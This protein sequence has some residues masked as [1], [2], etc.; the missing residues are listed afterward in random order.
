M[1]RG[2]LKILLQALE[3]EI[4]KA[5]LIAEQSLESALEIGRESAASP[6]MSGDREFAANQASLNQENLI[7]LKT[8]KEQVEFF[9][10]QPVPQK[11][12][13]ICSLSL[14]YI[15]GSGP[16]QFYL[17]LNSIYLEGFLFISPH[18]PL[19]KAII[20]KRVDE[21]F[22]YITQTGNLTKGRILKIE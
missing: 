12:Q 15:K 5:T 1:Q 9:Q 17:V 3:K 13:P 22:K 11:A 2:K 20:D 16:E 21:N 10:Q 14:F 18:S 6:S 8:L 19:G 4:Q 7:N